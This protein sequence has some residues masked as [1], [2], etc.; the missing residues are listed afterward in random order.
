MDVRY[1]KNN[2]SLKKFSLNVLCFYAMAYPLVAQVFMEGAP[3]GTNIVQLFQ[4]LPILALAYLWKFRRK[5]GGLRSYVDV[6]SISFVYFTSAAVYFALFY[7]TENKLNEIV[8][9]L[10][11]LSWFFLAATFKRIDLDPA[12]LERLT[13][14]FW[15]GA[16]SQCAFALWGVIW[17]LQNG[18]TSTYSKVAATTGS[19]DVSGK[20]VVAFVVVG[21]AI[22]AYWLIIKRGMRMVYA[23]SIVAGLAVVLASYNRATQLG[24]AVAYCYVMIACFRKGRFK[25]ACLLLSV[26]LVFGA[27]VLSSRGIGFATRWESVFSDQGSG[28]VAMIEIA[29]RQLAEPPSGG[30]L[31]FGRG[32]FQTQEMMYEELGIYIG[33]HNDLLDFA[34]AYGIVGAALCLGAIY[35]VLSFRKATPRNSIENYFASATGVFIVLTGLCTGMFQATYVFFMLISAQYYWISRARVKHLAW[36]RECLAEEIAWD[37]ARRELDEFDENEEDDEKEFE[38]D[39]DWEEREREPFVSREYWAVNCE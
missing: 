11:F 37:E 6:W 10:R 31:W 4:A 18:V 15:I 38:E 3:G 29:G 32:V 27:F 23:A 2:V 12:F 14:S 30:V 26:A 5:T 13:K 35:S 8:Y 36:Q 24:L 9:I 7:A 1:S 39:N 20:T 28:R 16:T 25:A 19:A 22:S 17:G 34:I 33:M 21:I